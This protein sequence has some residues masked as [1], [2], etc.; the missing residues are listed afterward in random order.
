MDGFARGQYLFNK[1]LILCNSFQPSVAFHIESSHLLC[2]TKQMTG[3]YMERYETLGWKG[4]SRVGIIGS[5]FQRAFEE[6]Y[7]S[8]VFYIFFK[9]FQVKIIKYFFFLLPREVEYLWGDQGL[10]E[11]VW[12]GQRLWLLYFLIYNVVRDIMIEYIIY[13]RFCVLYRELFL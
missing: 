5:G 12:G 1:F 2:S 10:V 13:W 6:P 3:F 9:N 11:I 7:F 8:N 4:L